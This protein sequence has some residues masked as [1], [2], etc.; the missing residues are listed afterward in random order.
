MA[1]SSSGPSSSAAASGGGGTSAASLADSLYSYDPAALLAL[2]KNKPWM[3]DAKFFK[4]ALIS[5]SCCAK[6]LMHAQSGV[7][8]GMA[9]PN[10]KPIEVM[11]LFIG[12]PDTEN[13]TR[14]I[15]TDAYPIDADGFETQVAT[16][17]DRVMAQMIDVSDQIELTRKEK[18]MGW[19]HSHPFDVGVHDHC[20]L[21]T[22]D[23]QTQLTWQ[24]SE[25]PNGN[26]FLA[27]V[28]DPLRSMAKG[29]PV[30]GAFRVY[31]P[32]YSPPPNE[33][34]DGKIITDE[35]TRTELWGSGW[36]RYHTLDVQYFMSSAGASV[37][38]MLS[39][40]V[41]WMRT[42]GSTPMLEAENRYAALRPLLARY[43]QSSLLTYSCCCLA[44]ILLTD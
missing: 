15:V 42:L 22:T 10:G 11:G 37:I 40:K 21:S 38:T 27:I 24:R 25:D 2:Q 19:Y 39:E 4:T 35:H 23:I 12:R 41:L 18:I 3:A 16:D 6:M 1:S 43:A 8:K 14:I 29:K 31:P 30:L 17:D 44:M 9:L 5:P 26:P 13:P 28:V 32:D 7:E 36:N 33:C 20:F 34:P